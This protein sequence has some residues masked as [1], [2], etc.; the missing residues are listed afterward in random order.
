MDMD[1]DDEVVILT[2]FGVNGIVRLDLLVSCEVFML[3]LL[4]IVD[5]EP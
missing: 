5:A 1:E 2:D 4:S 3:E